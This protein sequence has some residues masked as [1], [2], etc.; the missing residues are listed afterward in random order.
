MRAVFLVGHETSAV[1]RGGSANAIRYRCRCPHNDRAAH[2]I[3]HR[4][5]LAALID[6]VLTVEERRESPGV[7]DVGRG[8]QFLIERYD[9][10]AHTWFTE[11]LAGFDERCPRRTI[12]LVDAEHGIA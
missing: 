9:T 6:A 12:E 4:P 8:I 5:H 2:A 11:L 1:E 10:G 3:S 7:G